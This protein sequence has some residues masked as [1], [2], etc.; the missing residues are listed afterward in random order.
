LAIIGSDASTGRLA[1]DRRTQDEEQLDQ[2]EPIR[3]T[4]RVGDRGE[5]RVGVR[6]LGGHGVKR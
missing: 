1:A 5:T 4:A 2:L 3:P 6:W